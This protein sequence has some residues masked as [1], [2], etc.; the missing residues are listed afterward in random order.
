MIATIA[1][2]I[3]VIMASPYIFMALAKPEPAKVIEHEP[4]ISTV[5]AFEI[6]DILIIEET[7]EVIISYMPEFSY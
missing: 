5:A 7:G 1:T 4:T 6:E 3:L 2:I